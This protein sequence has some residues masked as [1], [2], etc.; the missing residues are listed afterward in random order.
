MPCAPCAPGTPVPPAVPVAPVAPAAPGAPFV[1]FAPLRPFAP[2]APVDPVDPEGPVAPVGPGEP[3][4]PA[5]PAFPA[6]WLVVRRNPNGSNVALGGATAR[7][8]C[9]NVS[10]TVVVSETRPC[11]VSATPLLATVPATAGV[12]R[13]LPATAPVLVRSSALT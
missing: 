10:T 9:G 11:D 6:G 8:G 1:P 3:A 7:T 12:S 13:I 4:T 2:A 5:G